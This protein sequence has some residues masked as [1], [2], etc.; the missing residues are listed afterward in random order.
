[1][2]NIG[3]ISMYKNKISDYKIRNNKSNLKYYRSIIYNKSLWYNAAENIISF[4]RINKSNSK[5]TEFK[6]SKL[7]SKP[8]SRS[9]LKTYYNNIYN[10]ISKIKTK[11]GGKHK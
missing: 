9:K 2:S 1:M 5:Y 7:S 3:D 8:I 6:S 4:S 11:N 10:K